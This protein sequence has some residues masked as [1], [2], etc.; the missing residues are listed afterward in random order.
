MK[1][2][3][4]G[5]N[6]IFSLVFFLFVSFGFGAI[7]SQTGFEP[8]IL[9]FLEKIPKIPIGFPLSRGNYTVLTDIEGQKYA[10]FDIEFVFYV[11]SPSATGEKKESRVLNEF[12]SSLSIFKKQKMAND[13]CHFAQWCWNNPMTLGG[14]FKP[15]FINVDGEKVPVR[16]KLEGKVIGSVLAKNL[17]DQKIY[18]NRSFVALSPFFHEF[19]LANSAKGK[20]VDF[21]TKTCLE[22][23][24]KFQAQIAQ[25]EMFELMENLQKTTT[26]FSQTR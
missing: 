1:V 5:L 18:S 15:R 14:N 9:S 7:P 22:E 10:L 2:V 25:Y 13:I 21:E 12:V 20:I 3:K 11:P 8:S 16:I 23:I 17:M 19:A 26:L 24:S 6:L 4:L